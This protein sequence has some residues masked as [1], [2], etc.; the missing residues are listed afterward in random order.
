M[1]WD[2]ADGY[3]VLFGGANASYV[4]LGDTW[5]FL[6][7]SWAEV[8]AEIAPTARTSSMFV[9]DPALGSDLLFGGILDNDTNLFGDMWTY[10]GGGWT[11]Q[12]PASI[13][14]AS[15]YDGAAWD[16][17]DGY[18]MQFGGI[19]YAHL[20]AADDDAQTWV[21]VTPPN[22]TRTAPTVGDVEHSI[23]ASVAITGGPAPFT[24]N[25]SFGDG[26]VAN[27]PGVQHEYGHVGT[28]SLNV[29]VTDAFNVSTVL[30]G[31]ILIN[32]DPTV[33][34]A[35]SPA[36]LVSGNVTLTATVSGGTPPISL[37]WSFG[38]GQQATGAGPEVVDYTAAGNFS[39][40]VTATDRV[41]VTAKAQAT[42][43]VTGHVNASK[44]APSGTP[45]ASS[46]FPWTWIVIAII[47]IAAVVGVLLLTRRG[48]G[49]GS[50]IPPVGP[51][52]PYSG[53]P[54]PTTGAP[55]GPPP[56]VGW[57]PP[58]PPP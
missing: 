53:V 18:L 1:A 13:P 34:L 39:A 46:S 26:T 44:T 4:N 38:N 48:K 5:R 47:A 21:Y 23:T 45:P 35:A 50:S 41:A 40:E 20:P 52:A 28:F 22:A 10:R 42:V 9:W 31:S 30:T 15:A 17:V 54:P 27:G 2:G 37:S 24:E 43:T 19:N 51:P 25:W 55:A 32:P 16:P 57:A 56:A 8:T 49:P 33:T 7:G 12:F 14:E 6:S 29:T 3:L 58:P 36:S 11:Q